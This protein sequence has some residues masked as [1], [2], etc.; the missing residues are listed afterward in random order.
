MINKIN[1]PNIVKVTTSIIREISNDKAALAALRHSNSILSNQAT[2]IWPL[3]FSKLDYEKNN[4][5]ADLMRKPTYQDIAIF[6]SL[7]CYAIFVQGNDEAKSEFLNSEKKESF[8]RT[9]SQLRKDDRIKGGLDR[10]VKNTLSSTNTDAVIHS[11]ISL[12]QILKAN[13]RSANVNYPDL[14]L[15]LNRFQFSFDA[16]RQVAIKWGRQYFWLDEKTL[17]NTNK[18]N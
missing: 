12:I 13:N 16:A 8:F 1:E 7:R 14:A 2:K 11:L 4:E 9:L 18:E 15:D 6:T 3:I 10:R 17:N 5:Y